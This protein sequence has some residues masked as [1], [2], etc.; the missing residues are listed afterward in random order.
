MKSLKNRT[1]ELTNAN[2]RLQQEIADRKKAEEEKAKLQVKLQQAEK[3][4]AI[5]ALA[6]DRVEGKEDAPPKFVVFN[7]RNL[8]LGTGGPA[9]MDATS[10]YPES[11][12]GST[13]MA[14]AAGAAGHNLTESQY[15]LASIKFRWNLSG[16]YQQVVPRYISTDET[17]GDEQEVLNRFFPDM[18][19]LTT[20]IFLQGY[21]WPFDPR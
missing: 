17:G 16:T 2:N 9:G 21:Q 12:L 18:E 7:A 3:M 19:T 15:G 6:L 20:A 13:G 5:G 14:L 4:E 1:I 8:V 11:Q 10:V